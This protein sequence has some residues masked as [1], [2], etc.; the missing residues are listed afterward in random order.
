MFGRFSQPPI[1][2]M[3]KA[4]QGR[5]DGCRGEESDLVRLE[6]LHGANS[7]LSDPVLR[8]SSNLSTVMQHWKPMPQEVVYSHFMLDKGCKTLLSLCGHLVTLIHIF[9]SLISPTIICV[10]VCSSKSRHS[11]CVKQLLHSL[12]TVSC[13]AQRQGWQC[14]TSTM[15]QCMWFFAHKCL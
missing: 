8:T 9:S 11:L 3:C 12:Q 14:E 1:I 2:A 7:N 15:R 6:R 5:L 10:K 4:N 13:A